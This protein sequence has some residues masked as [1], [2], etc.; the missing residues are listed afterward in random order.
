MTFSMLMAVVMLVGAV[1]FASQFPVEGMSYDV[2]DKVFMLLVAGCIMFLTYGF[3]IATKGK[4]VW[5]FI[6]SLILIGL[7]III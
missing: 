1:V 4:S 2:A 6:I 7:I 3:M 5:A